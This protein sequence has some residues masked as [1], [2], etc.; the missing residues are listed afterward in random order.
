MAPI[1]C[2]DSSHSTG[3][4]FHGEEAGNGVYVAS[5]WVKRNLWWWWE[6]CCENSKTVSWK[7]SCFLSVLGHLPLE[8]SQQAVRNLR[9]PLGGAP[10]GVVG[11]SPTW[12]RGILHELPLAAESPSVLPAEAPGVKKQRQ[13]ISTVLRVKLWCTTAVKGNACLGVVWSHDILGWFAM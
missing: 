10:I 3:H 7:Q 11:D 2:Y 5:L 6:W 12:A 4:C 8:C 9:Q 1:A 13:D